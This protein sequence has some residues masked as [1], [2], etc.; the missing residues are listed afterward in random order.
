MS[1]QDDSSS[2]VSLFKEFPDSV[3]DHLQ[4]VWG[5]MN[6]EQRH[7]MGDLFSLIPRTIRPLQDVLRIVADQYAPVV[8]TKH[9]VAIVGPANSG[10]STMF[11]RIILRKADRAQT[12][13]L[14]GVTREM[15]E[16]DAS[17][18]V[19]ADTPGA[20]AVGDLGEREK[21]IA[22]DTAAA[23][24]FL[25][26]MFDASHGV[27]RHEQ[28]LY[29]DLKALGKPFIVLLNKIDTVGRQAPESIEQ[30][31]RALD[32][33]PAQVLG[34]VATRGRNVGRVVLAI[35]KQEPALLAALGEALP[36]YRRK[37]AWQRILPATA[38][39]GV[40]GLTPIPIA[41]LI[42]LL[43]IQAGMVLTIARIYGRKLSVRNAKEII[44][45]FGVGLASRLAFQQLSKLGGIPGYVL[46]A[47]V[48]AATTLVMGVGAVNWFAHGEKPTQQWI[49]D[50][51]REVSEL[52]VYKLKQQGGRRP[53][54]RELKLRISEAVRHIERLFQR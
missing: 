44:T 2:H 29:A 9:R 24:D 3:R 41:D 23:A 40:V 30:A 42:P 18:F 37:L 12:G 1:Q 51:V 52:I 32:L 8:K 17:V 50:R 22:F 48:A 53:S 47:S 15:S 36:H 6:E 31:A 19:L 39:A 11:N 49:N 21:A 45:T 5:G 43:G 13:P 28:E 20:D 26:I 34:T 54:R 27:T 14:P 46:S 4:Q 7:E 33:E 10:K 35:A 25:V 38:S 16:S